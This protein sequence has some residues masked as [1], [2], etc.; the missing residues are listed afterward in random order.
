[1]K[2]WLF[3]IKRP[4]CFAA[5]TGCGNGVI[6]PLEIVFVDHDFGE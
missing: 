4:F 5:I 2:L 3:F 1:M 6:Q